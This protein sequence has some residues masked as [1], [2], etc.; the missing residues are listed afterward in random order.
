MSA[1]R[2][3]PT[4][5]ISPSSTLGSGV[6]IG[7]YAIVGPQ[8]T[9]EDEVVLDAHVVVRGR[10]RIGP[11]TRVSPFAVVG[12]TPQDRKFAG[13][14]SALTVGADCVIREHVT[15][16]TGTSGGRMLTSIGA[17]C[18]ILAGAHVGHDCVIGDDVILVN[19]VLLGGHV[20]IGN[21]AV[22]GGQSAVHQFVRIGSHAM[23]GGMTGVEADVIPYGVAIGDRARLDGLNLRGLKRRGFPREQIR[24]LVGA[25]RF[26]FQPGAP[27]KERLAEAL[28]KFAGMPPALDVV[29][30]LA[31]PSRRNICVPRS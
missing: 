16:N 17:R 4:A 3:D 7:P 18:L 6:E 2:I 1:T 27:L 29:R 31:A 23:I 10:T 14:A 22:L 19:H 28:E 30:F 24:A 26:L 13:E 9:L 15:V 25:Y 8:V 12:D 20:E 5:V 11:R 21:H